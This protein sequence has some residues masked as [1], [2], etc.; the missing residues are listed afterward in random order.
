MPT[1]AVPRGC[2]L[3]GPT[4][5]AQI[6]GSTGFLGER[7]ALGALLVAEASE[8]AS[9]LLRVAA[10][11]LGPKGES[12]D[13]HPLPWLDPGAP[14]R[15]ARRVDGSWVATF[16]ESRGQGTT[17]LG[18]WR[19]GEV[20][21]VGEGDRFEATD[22]ACSAGT[23]ALLTP[24]PGR[25]A[26]P[27]AEVWLGAEGDPLRAWK[28]VALELP[29][30]SAITP[31]ALAGVEPPLPGGT[32]P[33]TSLVVLLAQGQLVFFRVDG[34]Q[35][36]R[37]V[38]R[39]PAPHGV[40]DALGLPA[41]TAMV[42]GAPVDD[43]DCA[44]APGGPQGDPLDDESP[45]DDARDEDREGTRA[46]GGP[47]P[48]VGVGRAQLRF[49]QGDHVVD[50][51]TPAP[52]LRGALRRLGRGA[53]ATWI[54]PLG[55]RATRRVVYAVRLDEGGTPADAVIPVAD[56]ERYAIASSG[57][58]VDLWLQREGVVTWARLTCGVP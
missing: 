23:C 49:I 39:S 11:H 54:A 17:R 53:L 2:R 20:E 19:D 28:R 36:A 43:E 48:G 45:G 26:M 38:G 50:V 24:R 21:L 46:A 31:V 1:V 3:R 22:L 14:P 8:D 33:A 42:H 10:V 52:P 18:L 58:D 13:Q 15:F 30:V 29:G 47:A 41:P 5:Q 25:V 56:A 44:R 40:L 4:L 27:G 57:N 12:L 51:E 32:A 34:A 7:S 16:V 55:C 6:P 37:E 9:Q 35:G